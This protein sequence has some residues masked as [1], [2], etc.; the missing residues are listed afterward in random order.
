[1]DNELFKQLYEEAKGHEKQANL[2]NLVSRAKKYNFVEYINA[3]S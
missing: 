2:T 3:D 1:M